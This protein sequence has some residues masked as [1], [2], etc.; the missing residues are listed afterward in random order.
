MKK[1]LGVLMLAFLFV[2][3]SYANGPTKKSSNELVHLEK[4]H[5]E[6]S[7]VFEATPTII[8]IMKLNYCWDEPTEIHIIVNDCDYFILKRQ[9]V[10]NDN[11][12]KPFFDKQV[13]KKAKRLKQNICFVKVPYENDSAKVP[14]DYWI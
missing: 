14:Y 9:L 8:P 1:I 12:L 6:H 10:R 7:I 3:T 11:Y 13:N 4:I 2:G 5:L